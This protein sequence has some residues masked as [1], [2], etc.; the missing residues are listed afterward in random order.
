[1]IIDQLSLHAFAGAAVFIAFVGL[2]VGAVI[3]D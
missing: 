3:Q 1:M 2:L